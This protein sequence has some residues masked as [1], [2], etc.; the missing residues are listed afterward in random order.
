MVIRVIHKMQY[1]LWRWIDVVH[2]KNELNQEES[3]WVQRLQFLAPRLQCLWFP[4]TWRK[5]INNNHFLWGLLLANA[6]HIT[7]RK[8]IKIVLNKNLHADLLT[9]RISNINNRKYESRIDFFYNKAHALV[10]YEFLDFFGHHWNYQTSQNFEPLLHTWLHT[11]AAVGD[12][13]G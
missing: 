4:G 9:N 7:W 6:N 1:R 2:S 3:L 11:V 10:Y 8:Q 13:L 12:H 5:Q